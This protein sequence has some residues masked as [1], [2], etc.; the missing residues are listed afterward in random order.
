[1]ADRLHLPEIVR[2]AHPPAGWTILWGHGICSDSNVPAEHYA[3]DLAVSVFRA[4]MEH[5]LTLGCEFVTMTEGVARLKAG[6]PLDRCV[7]VTFDDGFR[8]VFDRAYPIMDELGVKGCVYVVADYI[9]TGCVLWTDKVDL[10]CRWQG[11]PRQLALE[12][13]G[14]LR[15]YPLHDYRSAFDSSVAIKR[16]FR[17]VPDDV[18]RAYFTQIEEAF[19]RIDDVPDDYRFATWEQ[20][21]GVDP[22]LVEIGN[23]TR[24]HPNLA[25]VSDRTALRWEIDGARAL[26]ESKLGVRIRHFCYPAGSYDRRVI[27]EVEQSGHSSAVTIEYGTNQSSQPVYELRRLGLPGTLAQFKARMSGLESAILRVRRAARLA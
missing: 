18:R 20:L 6:E 13:P 22:T 2:R 26:L 16:A 5:L 10:V 9:G 27:D 11:R 23:H 14:G 12:L 3:R 19:A 25:N 1:M 21:R 15:S 8:S 24:T 4:Q 17:S 7:T